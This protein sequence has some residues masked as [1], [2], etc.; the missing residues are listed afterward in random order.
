M[1]LTEA[2]CRSLLSSLA[3]LGA[4]TPVEAVEYDFDPVYFDADTLWSGGNILKRDPTEPNRY[5]SAGR[6]E[7]PK[8]PEWARSHP[9]SAPQ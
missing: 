5:K 2:G 9:G 1:E 7:L 4:P 8:K 3:Q 6:Y